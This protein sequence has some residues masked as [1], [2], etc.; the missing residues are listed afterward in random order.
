MC[1]SYQLNSE[2]DGVDMKEF[3]YK[4]PFA[5]AAEKV[6][7]SWIIDLLWLGYKRPIEFPDL[8]R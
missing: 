4:H 8:G 3:A 2:P 6:T 5:N 7:F 1:S